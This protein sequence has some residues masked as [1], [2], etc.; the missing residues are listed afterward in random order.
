M[1]RSGGSCNAANSVTGTQA[2][3]MIGTRTTTFL[4]AATRYMV[5]PKA[6]MR[7]VTERKREMR[8]MI[9]LLGNAYRKSWTA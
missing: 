9:N 7:D 5:E 8:P 2:K 3:T 1:L 4:R 6:I